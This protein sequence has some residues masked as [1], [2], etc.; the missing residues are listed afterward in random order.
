MKGCYG[1]LTFKSFC[2]A[3][4]TSQKRDEQY[5]DT[6]WT[7]SNEHMSITNAD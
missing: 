6:I 2:T 5:V 3:A 7:V 4:E 1:Q